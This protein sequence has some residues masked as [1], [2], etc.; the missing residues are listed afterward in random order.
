MLCQADEDLVDCDDEVFPGL[1]QADDGAQG[2]FQIFDSLMEG[3][4]D[5]AVIESFKVETIVAINFRD[6]I[7]AGR[8]TFVVGVPEPAVFRNSGAVPAG[9]RLEDVLWHEVQ[10]LRDGGTQMRQ[11]V[12]RV[13]PVFVIELNCLYEDSGPDGGGSFQVRDYAGLVPTRD[14][15]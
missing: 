10:P 9:V 3:V 4:T 13:P 6:Q 14:R 2:C 1:C 8:P 12:V 5:R 11:T 7:R 15:P